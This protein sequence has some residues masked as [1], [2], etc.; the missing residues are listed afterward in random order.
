MS[1]DFISIRDLTLYQFNYL[2][3][4][5]RQIKE[6]PHRFQN[7]LKNKTLALA[8]QKPSLRA[9]VTFEAGMLQLG[10]DAIYLASSDIQMG[11]RE[12][13]KDVCKS[14]ERWVDGVAIRTSNHKIVTDFAQDSRIPV[15][16]A[17][18]DFLHPCQAISDFFTLKESRKDLSSIKLAYIGDGN[19]VCHSLLLAAAKA[20]TKIAVATPPGYE[21]SPQI[22]KQAETDGNQTGFQVQVTHDL[23]EAAR[24]AD[25]IYTGTWASIGQE[26]KQQQR[27]HIFAPY[28]VNKE[29]MALAN[30]EFLFMHCLPAHRGEEVSDEIIDSPHS[31]VYDQVENRLHVQ[32]AI[33]V[34]LLESEK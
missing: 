28:Q 33:M 24:G 3:D 1:K 32:K 16:N 30:P 2:L 11:E 12:L 6:K 17:L 7:N 25:V 22:L 15:I 10:G 23:S 21:P 13:P 26:D 29:L 20:G 14:L 34:L 5:A 9:K 8:F 4:L 27:A 18:T 19:N 31:I